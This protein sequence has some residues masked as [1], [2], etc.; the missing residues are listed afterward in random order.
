MS[1]YRL[2]SPID[3]RSSGATASGVVNIF[4]GAANNTSVRANPALTVNRLFSLPSAA[5]NIGEYVKTDGTNVVFGPGVSNVTALPVCMEICSAG[6]NVPAVVS[7]S[8]FATVGNVNWRGTATE[9]TP[10]L[11]NAIV[12]SDT[13]TTGEVRLFNRTAGTV[14]AI[15]SIPA[16]AA[17][18][19]INV[20]IT[21]GFTAGADIIDIQLRR[22]SFLTSDVYLSWIL[23][24]P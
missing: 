21:G 4:N 15:A 12:A 14:A 10:S 16:A 23:I 11:V 13:G 1:Q 5:G 6:A 9:G 8:T 20:P 19:N 17:F 7:S 24:A 2:S 22:T 18:V 3:V